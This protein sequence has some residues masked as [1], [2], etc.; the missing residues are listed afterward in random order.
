MKCGRDRQ[1]RDYSIIGRL[2]IVCSIVDAPDTHSK[3]VT[4]NALIRKN[5]YSPVPQCYIIVGLLSFDIYLSVCWWWI[6]VLNV[7]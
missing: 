6:R 1:V 4:F 3:H 5:N 7:T 2:C